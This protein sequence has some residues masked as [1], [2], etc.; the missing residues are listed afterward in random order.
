[1]NAAPAGAPRDR[2]YANP[3]AIIVA[4][5]TGRLRAQFYYDCNHFADE[6]ADVA[7]TARI[8]AGCY[9]ALAATIG[10]A[11][12]FVAVLAISPS[13]VAAHILHAVGAACSLYGF[14]HL[15][16]RR[17][18]QLTLSLLLI[19]LLASIGILGFRHSG[20]IPPIMA[21]LPLTAALIAYYMQGM[22]RWI[23]IGVA[24]C[25]MIFV[26]LT[27]TGA[28]GVPTTYTS[29][30]Y[31]IV[32][33]GSFAFSTTCLGCVAWLGV[34]SRD[35]AIDTISARNAEPLESA[36]RSRVALEAAK[37]GLWDMPDASLSRFH[38][39]DSFTTITGYTAE[40]MNV[41]NDNISD[42]VHADDIAAIRDAFAVG[43]R[44]M[45]RIRIDFRLMTRTRGYRWFSVRAGYSRNADGTVRISGS[46]QDI[47]FL[48]AAEEALRT[49]R[50]R[51]REA[52]RAKSDFIA[53]MSHEVRTPL[54][55]ILGSVEVLRGQARDRESAELI[56]LIDDAGRG[57][58]TIV[59]D[60]LDVS[61]IEAGKIELVTQPTD[62]INLVSRTVDFW[63]PEAARKGLQIDFPPP[64]ALE[65]LVMA[66]PTRV[67]QI[68][69]NLISNAIKF[70]ET[71][72]VAVNLSLHPASDNRQEV[73]VSVVD[74]GVGVAN[75]VAGA[76]FAPFEQAP[77]GSRKPGAGLGL[78]ISR[79]LARMMDGDVTLEPERPKGSHFRLTFKA[80]IA[81]PAD[82]PTEETFAEPDWRGR[83]VL[84]VDDNENNRRIAQLL[85]SRIGLEALTCSSGAEALQLCA[86][87]RFDAI[88]MDIVM[89]E[90]DGVG[91]LRRLRADPASPNQHT[92]TIA[93]TARLAPE[94]LAAYAAA[95]FD[96]V[97]G[98][99]ISIRELAQTIAPFM[100]AATAAAAG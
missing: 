5:F 74:T 94:D 97:A 10:W 65:T 83:C 23:A 18:P 67:R 68:L 69:D 95:G 27:S 63:R 36:S 100:L 98:K 15:R 71:G 85:L 8:V 46:M 64:E 59:N 84:C 89:P 19:G 70:T 2:R 33:F 20:V 48:K 28:L 35:Y 88:L 72:G 93:L 51:A 77:G 22:L 92:P 45:S 44:R 47:N 62:M 80:P 30:G 49:G 75:A 41:I 13:N 86:S 25:V 76:I 79:R 55:A 1:M 99:P 12:S 81:D 39:S 96:G 42:Y 87:R 57:L 40:E 9:L 58:L 7:A 66:D 38:V 54:N 29:Q 34:L 3:L 53:V 60:L 43:R 11:V 50:D 61:R 37:V 31:L 91:T 73:V 6:N 14:L 26:F 90:L 4:F 56:G 52:S 16:W 24:I 21:T 17:D 78:F 82:D 32:A